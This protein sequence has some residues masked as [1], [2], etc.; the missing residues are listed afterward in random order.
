MIMDPSD[1]KVLISY[2]LLQ[3]LLKAIEQIPS[4]YEDL[5]RCQDRIT[6]LQGLYSEVLNKVDLLS[7]LL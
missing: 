6:A 1:I 3:D 4:L 7:K 5:K 2:E